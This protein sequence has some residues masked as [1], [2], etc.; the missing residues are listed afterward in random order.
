[1]SPLISL[2]G[3]AAINASDIKQFKSTIVS[4]LTGIY[5]F[6]GKEMKNTSKYSS[7]FG[8]NLGGDLSAASNARWYSR[9]DWNFKS[10]QWS[11]EANIVRTPDRHIFNLRGGVTRNNVTVEAFITNLFNNHTY[12]SIADN[13]TIDPSLAHL[14]Y[15]SALVVG[16][17]EL[18]T[19]GL[20]LKIKM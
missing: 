3:A 4:Q 5:D 2:D 13:Y 19:F 9:F 6:S 20:Q 10:G 17:P 16:L 14:A 18:R 12:T 7:N 8:I 11:N 1:M 15:N